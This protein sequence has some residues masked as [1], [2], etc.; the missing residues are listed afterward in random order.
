MV[1]PCL[2][3]FRFSFYTVRHKKNPQTEWSGDVVEHSPQHSN[4]KTLYSPVN[5][6][7]RLHSRS[8]FSVGRCLFQT[9]VLS[10]NSFH[11]DTVFF[12]SV[13]IIHTEAFAC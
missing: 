3:L 7:E 4:P 1:I 11:K 9:I 8:G 2:Y 12:G 5:P 6:K 10:S 13:V